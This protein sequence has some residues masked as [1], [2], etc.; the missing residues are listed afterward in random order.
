[1]SESPKFAIT[2]HDFVSAKKLKQFQEVVGKSHGCF[3]QNPSKL[4]SCDGLT[5]EYSVTVGFK[6]N[7]D[8]QDFRLRWRQCITQ[9]TDKGVRAPRPWWKFWG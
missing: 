4:P 9:Y 7:D 1:M 8:H 3:V 5:D 2:I 6:T